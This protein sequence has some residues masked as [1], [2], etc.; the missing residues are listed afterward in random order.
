MTR[1]RIVV[2]SGAPGTGKSTVAAVIA[3]RVRAALLSST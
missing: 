1:A 2:V 3:D